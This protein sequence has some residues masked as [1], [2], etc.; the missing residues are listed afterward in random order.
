M[1]LLRLSSLMGL[2]LKL[3]Q[4]KGQVDVRPFKKNTKYMV[5]RREKSWRP[6]QEWENMK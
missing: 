6:R 4:K 3:R 5:A 2:G 1:T